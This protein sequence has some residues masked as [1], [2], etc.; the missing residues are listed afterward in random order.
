V[1][2]RIDA[3]FSGLTGPRIPAN[4]PGPGTHFRAPHAAPHLTS[5][6]MAAPRL[7]L[8]RQDEA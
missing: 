4:L 5:S 8:I 7:P 1:T 2:G 3:G 6:L